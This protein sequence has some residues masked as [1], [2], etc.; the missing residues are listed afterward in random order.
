MTP[1]Q[2]DAQQSA[3]PRAIVVGVVIATVLLGLEFL[4]ATALARK[5]GKDVR[6]GWNL[7]PVLTV[8]RDANPGPVAAD[9]LVERGVPEQFITGTVL[10]PGDR[11]RALEH[12]LVTPLSKGDM[13]RWSDFDALAVTPVLFAARDLPV[14]A[15]I[16]AGDVEVRPFRSE[17]VTPGWLRAEAGAM[18]LGKQVS[19]PLAKGDPVLDSHF[20]AQ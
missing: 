17:L 13:V 5:A 2:T 8:S 10:K 3:V 19:V 14:G 1:A 11:A 12:R 18:V 4:A 15:T 20:A 6:R 7:V 9:L 16:A